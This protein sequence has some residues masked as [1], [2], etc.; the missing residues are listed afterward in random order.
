M[1]KNLDKALQAI[2]W[3]WTLTSSSTRRAFVN[4]QVYEMSGNS[5]GGPF[6]KRGEHKNVIPVCV[7]LSFLDC[8]HTDSEVQTGA[9]L[10]EI[11]LKIELFSCF[12]GKPIKRA[13]KN[14]CR[15]NKQTIRNCNMA[16]KST[17]V[18]LYIKKKIRRFEHA[19]CFL[20]CRQYWR[21]LQF[22]QLWRR[23]WPPGN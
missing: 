23:C 13:A 14:H 3:S 21:F 19:V 16:R 12:D 17:V 20:E 10:F 15:W 6:W 18:Y 9:T 11:T 4:Y 2:K 8:I 7:L 5:N 22:E 1:R